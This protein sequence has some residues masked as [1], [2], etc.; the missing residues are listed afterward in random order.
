M[1]ELEET[2]KSLLE[3]T[4][5]DRENP[6]PMITEKVTRYARVKNRKHTY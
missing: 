4:R 2:K 6:E 1:R 3:M 5:L